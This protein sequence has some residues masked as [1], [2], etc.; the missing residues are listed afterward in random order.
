[1][2]ISK[3]WFDCIA[4]KISFLVGL[5]LLGFLNV[6]DTGTVF[7]L[8]GIAIVAGLAIVAVWARGKFFKR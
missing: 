4:M 6:I 5:W 3:F 1:M 8:K 2:A 7:T